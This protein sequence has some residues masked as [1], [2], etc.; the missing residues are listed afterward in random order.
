MQNCYIYNTKI[1]RRL[2]SNLHCY[3]LL[4]YF[5]VIVVAKYKILLIEFSATGLSILRVIFFPF[6]FFFW[7]DRVRSDLYRI[8]LL[9][10]C[11]MLNN[12]YF[13]FKMIIS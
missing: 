4:L 7:L 1:F 6:F 9:S 3:F 10:D 2:S 13:T 5:V 8:T 12:C 11:H